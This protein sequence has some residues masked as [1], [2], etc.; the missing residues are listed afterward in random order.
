MLQP[1]ALAPWDAGVQSSRIPAQGFCE[2]DIVERARIEQMAFHTTKDQT[3]LWGQGYTREGVSP[4]FL[5]PW[6]P[7][8][9][10]VPTLSVCPRAPSVTASH[11][12]QKER[13]CQRC[14]PGSGK[15]GDSWETQ[16]TR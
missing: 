10:L 12:V 6:V 13:P 7:T 16:H 3:R 14:Y 1:V 5:A 15:R 11:S 4:L 8:Q 2:D 9:S